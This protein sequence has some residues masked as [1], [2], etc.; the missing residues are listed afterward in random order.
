MKI[1]K[2]AVKENAVKYQMCDFVKTTSSKALILTLCIHYNLK[3][4]AI[5]LKTNFKTETNIKSF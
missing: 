4:K 2:L 1:W 5:E 3:S